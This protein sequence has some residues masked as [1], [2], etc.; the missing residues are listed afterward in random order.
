MSPHEG[1][2]AHEKEGTQCLRIRSGTNHGTE[3]LHPPSQ[4][5]LP[6]KIQDAQLI[7]NCKQ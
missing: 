4:A 1:R 3:L 6:E 7:S 2:K 5:G